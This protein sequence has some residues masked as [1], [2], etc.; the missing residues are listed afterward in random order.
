MTSG[1]R[2]LLAFCLTTN[3]AISLLPGQT[4]R[5]YPWSGD[6]W[7]SWSA[8]ERKIFVRGYIDGNLAGS[9]SACEAA[10]DLFENTQDHHLGDATHPSD[11]PSVRCLARRPTFSKVGSSRN[12]PTGLSTYTGIITEF[13]TKHP[14]YRKVSFDFLLLYLNDKK[15]KTAD[16]LFEMAKRGEMNGVF[17]Y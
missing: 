3:A 2:L 12:G 16:E 5:P 9:W 4:P 6:E 8:S 10:N 14:E 7:L 17:V 11:I 13:Y 1:F 15:F